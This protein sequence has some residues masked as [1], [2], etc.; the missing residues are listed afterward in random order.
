VPT[1][2]RIID[3]PRRPRFTKEA[4]ALFAELE[5]VPVRSRD[6]QDWQAASR[7]LAA[8]L[9]IEDE[10]FCS[11]CHVHDCSTEPSHSPEYVAHHAWFRVRAVREALLEAIATERAGV[12]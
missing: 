9:G 3:R 1:N 10:W 2:R 5:A 4:L 8:M 11:G 12:S 7:R 6:Q